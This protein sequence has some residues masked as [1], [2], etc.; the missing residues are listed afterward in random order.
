MRSRRITSRRTSPSASW[1]RLRT[2]SVAAGSNAR[3]R[4]RRGR[5]RRSMTGSRRR[6]PGHMSTRSAAGLLAAFLEYLRLNRNT[7]VHT[8]AA[9]KS[10]LSQ[11]LEF[12]AGHLEKKFD[13]VRPGDLD[14]ALVRAFMA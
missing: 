5:W 2:G 7:S 3:P 4:F 6:A 1:N 11:F 14:F 13:S 8:V 10:D 9:Y 12:A